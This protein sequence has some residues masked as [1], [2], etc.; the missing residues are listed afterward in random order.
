MSH[1]SVGALV[2]LAVTNPG[3]L[4]VRTTMPQRIPLLS[5]PQRWDRQPAD[6]R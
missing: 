5:P 1:L 4:P 6:N 2:L 3:L